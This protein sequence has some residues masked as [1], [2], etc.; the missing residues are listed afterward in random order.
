MVLIEDIYDG[1][2]NIY[3]AYFLLILILSEFPFFGDY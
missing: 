3:I 2:A 1:I